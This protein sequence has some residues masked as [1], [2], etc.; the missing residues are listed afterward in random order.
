LI[1]AL[2]II[3]ADETGKKELVALK[4]GFR[5]SELS[6]QELLLDLKMRGLEK[7]PDLSIGDGA[8][9]F[10]KALKAV[11]GTSKK[12]RCW[13]HKAAN[14]L[15]KLPN[16]SQPRVKVMLQDI[17][18]SE[19]KEKADV[20]FDK[21]LSTYGDKYPKVAECLTKDR[22]DLLSFY[23]FPAAHWH[24]LRTTNPIESV[25]ATVRLRT[26]KTKG[27]LSLQTGEMMT[28]KLIESASKR[29]LRLRGPQHLTGVIQGVVFKNGA[30]PSEQDNQKMNLKKE[31][32]K[33]AA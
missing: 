15:N 5:E 24:H 12:Q 10:W 31:D 30:T 17:W 28:F 11:Y 25:F 22:D 26:D 9:G 6:W 23:D 19:T 33:C 1:I 29:W 20:A 16:S 32:Q 21:L 8:L 13:L 2:V 7:G 27:S 18:K 3:G 14:V 4:G